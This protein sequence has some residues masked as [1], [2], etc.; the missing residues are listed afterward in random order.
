M[1]R[2]TLLLGGA[3]AGGALLLGWGLLPPRTRL[4]RREL[5]AGEPGTVA[6]NGWI[7]IGADGGVQL[8]MPR[9]EMGQGVHTALAMLVAEEL[10]VPLERVELVPARADAIYG[11][12]AMFVA[13]LPFAPRDKEPGR[14]T[15]LLKTGEWIV[16]KLAREL[17]IDATGGSS[18]VADAWEPLRLAAATA[19]A[20]LVGAASLAWRLPKQ[21]ITIEAGVLSHPSGARAHFGE[22]AAAAAGTPPGT[23]GLKP[24]AA[25][26]L[27]G[28]AAPRID[29]A[30]KCDGRAVF[31]LDVRPAGLLHAAARMCPVLGGEPGRIANVDAVL[32]RPGVERVVRLRA[33]A[34]GTAG[35]AVVGRTS[36]HARQAVEA[37][38]IEW[39]APPAGPR[40]DSAAILDALEARAREAFAA[41]GGF[42]FRAEG[43]PR[44]AEQ[45]V[46][47]RHVEALYRAPYLAHMALEPINCTAQVEGGRVTVWVPTQVPGIA[48]ALAAR[49]AG[50]A[51]DA[52][53]LHLTL[54]G[55]GFG[56]RLDAEVVGQAVEIA[57]ECGGR[58]VQLL[59]SRE[60]DT[61]HDCYRPAAAAMLKATLDADGRPLALRAV[62]ASDAVTP[63]WLERGLPR[64]AAPID[65]PDRSAVEGLFDLPYDIAHVR[66]AH[67][68]TRS[69]VPVGFW[70]SVGHSYNAF[71][72]EAFV[73]ECAHAAGQDPV[74]WRLA[75]LQGLPRHAAVL[76]LA[77]ERAGWEQPPAAG[78][79][80]GVA[81]HESFGSIVAQVLEVSLPPGGA[82]R[83]HRVVCAADCGTVLNPGIVRQQFEGAILFGL[84]AALHGRIDI[85]AGVV[86]QRNYP[87]QP[88]PRLADTPPIEVHLLDSERPP[89]GVGEPGVPPLAPALAN[90]LFA[91][92]GRR[93]RE[94]PLRP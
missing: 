56:R 5:L 37:L 73:D 86:R 16:A 36:W 60:E 10:D 48:R 87:D 55:G 92:T 42:A 27:I 34:G 14:E 49:A 8:A 23:V 52:V 21:E 25:W 31:G 38:A 83:V 26:T 75:A 71:F 74:A 72:L 70:R 82:P 65:L 15:E 61:T 62:C 58:P 7:R 84:A 33:W 18:S 11:N 22:V 9:A 89:A 44:T 77:A 3:A 24:R 4:G 76:R 68:A 90:A 63:R 69:G 88:L 59:W 50:V 64:L 2:R 13:Q 41:D 66:V 19:R 57:Q 39:R 85:E 47:V 29:L 40:P 91:L 46:G 17:G 45:A 30:A 54:L 28:R 93:L 35:V 6:L 32:R 78:R 20:Q 80:R 94:L 81:L 1:K 79:A 12:V 43:A 51:E 53:T 67:A